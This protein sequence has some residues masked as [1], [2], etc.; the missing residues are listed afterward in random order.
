[1]TSDGTCGPIH[2]LPNVTAICV[3]IDRLPQNTVVYPLI[4]LGAGSPARDLVPVLCVMPGGAKPQSNQK[5]NNE[6]GRRWSI[7]MQIAVAVGRTL[8][9]TVFQKSIKGWRCTPWFP[10]PLCSSP[11]FSSPTSQLQAWCR[12]HLFFLTTLHIIMF[13]RT[14][15]TFLAVG[16]LSVNA[17]T[18]PVARSPA[19]EPECE[20]PRSFSSHLTTI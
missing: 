6:L 3:S 15:L 5:I 9:P 16:A 11:Q 1:M 12:C 17:L 4:I 10:Q 2:S 18:T 7:E 20:F 19:P 13:I 14:V 8:A